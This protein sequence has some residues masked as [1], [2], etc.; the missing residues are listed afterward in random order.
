[1]GSS[2]SE[3]Q[4]QGESQTERPMHGNLLGWTAASAIRYPV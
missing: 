1:V 3:E 2:R 4:E